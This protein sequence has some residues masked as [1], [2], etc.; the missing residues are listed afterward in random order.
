LHFL[1]NARIV[2]MIRDPRSVLLSQKNK[3]RRK[4]MGDDNM[5]LLEALRVWINYH[6]ITISKL[7]SSALKVAMRHQNNPNFFHQKYEEFIFTPDK[8]IKKIC[9]FCGIK[10]DA[11]MLDIPQIGSSV[12][13]DR[14]DKKGID[15]SRADSWKQGGLNDTEIYLAQK[16]TKGAMQFFGYEHINVKPNYLYL[17]YYCLTFPLKIMLSFI[18]NIGRMKNVLE[19]LKRRF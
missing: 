12:V 14:L 16:I 2:N 11:K 9:D 13:R 18:I 5:P 6:P 7:W 4:F 17:L 15:K 1:P 10:F 3:W 8:S 19:A